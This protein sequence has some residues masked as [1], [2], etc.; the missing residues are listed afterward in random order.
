MLRFDYICSST[1]FTFG[2]YSRL[3][4]Y[5]LRTVV[6]VAPKKTET[7]TEQWENDCILRSCI[8]MHKLEVCLCP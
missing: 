1:Y 4:N 3:K 6:V 8:R 5:L 2:S 7:H